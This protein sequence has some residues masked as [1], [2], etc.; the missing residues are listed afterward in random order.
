M[1]NRRAPGRYVPSG[2]LVTTSTTPM[3]T[4]FPEACCPFCGYSLL[5]LRDG[6]CPECGAAAPD[7]PI[8]SPWQGSLLRSMMRG[9]AAV[10]LRPYRTLALAAWPAL[11]P[12]CRA[13]AFAAATTLPVIALWGP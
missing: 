5:G 2:F 9:L 7:R 11:T 4:I 1:S 12:T 3:G 13:A 10:L 8:A 6:R